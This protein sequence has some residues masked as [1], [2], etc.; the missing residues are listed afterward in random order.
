[1]YVS[2]A[3]PVEKALAPLPKNLRRIILVHLNKL[4][5]F[6]ATMQM[7]IRGLTLTDVKD[8]SLEG[9]LNNLKLLEDKDGNK[10]CLRVVRY[11]IRVALT[12]YLSNIFGSMRMDS[13]GGKIKFLS[14]KEQV[15]RIN[16][17]RTQNLPVPRVLL[18]G[19][20]WMLTNFVPGEPFVDFMKKA[21]EERTSIAVKSFL[22]A[23][24]QT[25][26]SGEC[27]WDRWG[28]NEI[29]HD[30]KLSAF[31]DFDWEVEFPKTT[32]PSIPRN[33]DLVVAI[34]ACV[35]YTEHRDA[36]LEAISNFLLTEKNSA[37]YDF[38]LLPNMLCGESSFYD[39]RYKGKESA[40]NYKEHTAANPYVI[41]LAELIKSW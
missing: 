11:G 16:R 20:Y 27:L 2:P 4:L 37:L 28:P 7:R 1:M 6:L 40:E 19:K 33:I 14:V 18:H 12:E 39:D 22:E 41:K 15:E 30:G 35:R 24:A 31:I 3:C 8:C 5:L 9:N 32:K 17:L 29:I 38:S 34:R 25:H 36:A 23:L 26:K 21:D 13:Y 10:Y